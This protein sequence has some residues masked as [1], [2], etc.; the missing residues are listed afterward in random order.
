MTLYITN[1]T[2]H[3]SFK[4]GFIFLYINV[5]SFAQNI[6]QKKVDSLQTILNNKHLS[7]K[8][9]AIVYGLLADELKNLECEKSL[10][11]AS[12]LYVISEKVQYKKGIA[13]FY[14]ISASNYAS[15]R[16]SEKAIKN[17]KE[18]NKI[19]LQLKDTLN[20]LANLNTISRSSN[21]LGNIEQ[22]IKIANN[23]INFT[24]NDKF[25]QEIA[26]LYYSLCFFYNIKNDLEKAFYCITE[27]EKW[28]EKSKIKQYGKLK[29]YQQLT[30]LFI[31]NDKFDRAIDYGLKSI[32]IGK[33]IKIHELNMCTLYSTVGMAY[34]SNNQDDEAIKYLTKADDF[35]KNQGSNEI[36]ANNLVLLSQPYFG[37]KQYKKAISFSKEVLKLS[38]DNHN[39]FMALVTIGSS[40][41]ELGDYGNALVYQTKAKDL[42]NEI[43]DADHQ[44]S[45][46]LELSKTY[47]KLGD[48]KNAYENLN[49][50]QEIEINF[51]NQIQ[52]KNIND[53]EIKY[54]T[55]EKE[56]E[57][58]DLT[59]ESQK[60]KALIVKKENQKNFLIAIIAF[61]LF[62]G[63][64]T[65]FLYTKIKKKNYKLEIQNSIIEEQNKAISKSN[66]TI[67]K[68]FSIISHDLRGPFNVLLGY[69]NYINENFEELNEEELKSYLI[70]L[71]N[72]AQNN[73]N[74]TQ[75][76]LN[77][78][79]KQQNGISINKELCQLNEIVEKS[80]TTL[81][82][83]ANQKN[84]VL[85]KDFNLEEKSNGYF[86]KDIIFNVLYNL[87]SNS[88]KYSKDNTSI[89]IKTYADEQFVYVETKDNGIGMSNEKLQ[90]LN[91]NSNANEF[92]FVK[93]NNEYQGGFGLTYAKE[94]VSLYGG[95]LVFDSDLGEG[96]TVIFYF[97]ISSTL[98]QQDK[99]FNT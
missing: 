26:H 30:Q 38:E 13:D 76:L 77:W 90:K 25:S 37:L 41:Y 11:Y 23:G 89:E 72:A 61:G 57:L 56:L 24:K 31:K 34:F 69:T 51:L 21:D 4:L 52:E 42:I 85:H 68:T 65:Y 91:Q 83:L 35:Y 48:F 16:E 71:N 60:D 98:T 78:S 15:L 22:A 43:N 64:I 47:H 87:I 28:Y 29:C 17:A 8:E 39:I 18:S 54:D 86:D 7:L 44:R 36:R 12:K 49:K 70:K 10:E 95:Q 55:K 2:F 84:I 97:L 59:I 79:L 82:P 19:Y 74:F 92:T 67:K 1:K 3:K 20:F 73:F 99:K 75:Q 66:A 81:M 27:A 32:A 50:Y 94:L 96:T 9:K 63:L 80:I 93:N 6:N 45:I 40:Y 5:V 46:Y 53:L 88:I 62:L 58:K 33:E 14:R